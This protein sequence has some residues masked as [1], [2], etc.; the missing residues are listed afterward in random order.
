MFDVGYLSWDIIKSSNSLP[1]YTAWFLLSPGTLDGFLSRGL[2]HPHQPPFTD[3]T[4]PDIFLDII[5]KFSLRIPPQDSVTLTR[6]VI[7]ELG[8]NIV[9][10]PPSDVHPALMR[11]LP[12]VVLA[13]MDHGLNPKGP[14]GKRGNTLL[15]CLISCSSGSAASNP[16]QRAIFQRC[17][18]HGM[19][20]FVTNAL[21][22]PAVQYL[23][24]LRACLEFKTAYEGLLTPA[25]E[26][27]L[28]LPQKPKPQQPKC[29]STTLPQAK[30]PKRSIKRSDSSGKED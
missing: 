11:H 26:A 27:Y 21:G 19:D 5:A 17:R 29:P 20:I 1:T 4:F 24:S 23:P 18:D 8:V 9:A 12:E 14:F 16:H 2:M 6:R 22:E 7:S 28:V 13:L 10:S 30:R 15:H 3:S 25:E